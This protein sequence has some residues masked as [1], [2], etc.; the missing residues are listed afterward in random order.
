MKVPD[1]YP[2]YRIRL[3]QTMK[4][5]GVSYAEMGRR[6]GQSRRTG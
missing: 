3:R 5:Q 4:T 6:I 1:L 2:F